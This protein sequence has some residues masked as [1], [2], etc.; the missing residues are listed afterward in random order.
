MKLQFN[1]IAI[2]GLGLIGAP[3]CLNLVKGKYSVSVWN[4][5]RSK[6]EKLVDAGAVALE[7]PKEVAKNSEIIITCVSDSKDV[8]EVIL[9]DDGVIEGVREGSIVID[10][11]TISPSVTR[12]IANELNS[13]NAKMLDAP[14]SGGVN[15]AEAGVLSIMVG[16]DK[17]VLDNVRP[18]L[19]ELGSKITYCGGNG[20]GQVTKLS[21]QIFGMGNLAAMCEAIVF[22]S[23][24]GADPEAL[25]NAWSAGAAGSW[26]VDNLGE[27]V[28]K[29]E[30]EPGFMVKLAQ[31]DL[32]LVLDAASQM[33]VALFTTPIISQIFRATQQSGFSDEGIHA[34]VKILE[35][36]AGLN[37]K[38][39]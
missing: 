30:F 9:G 18:I 32:N 8:K 34:Y 21:N 19:N 29:R 31:K 7:S 24:A 4:R 28:F 16:G 23:K 37:V 33:D 15:G 27:K 10:M 11:S 5:T 35:N 2:I 13:V 14:V 39:K 36:I 3:M 38:S 25:I 12:E 20:M 22:A 26:M 1:N 17:T 6:V